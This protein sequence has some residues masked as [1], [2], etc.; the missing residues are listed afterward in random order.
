[1][2]QIHRVFLAGALLL[3][4]AASCFAAEKIFDP[5]ADSAKDLAAAET[6]A[7]Q[8]HKRILLDV[9]GNWCS[10]C[11]LLEHTL[12]ENAALK[13][14]LETNYIVVHV[15][16]SQDRPN[17]AFLSRYPKVDGYPYLFVL[18]PD[19]KLI[20]AQPTDALEQ[21]HKLNSGYN[22]TAVLDFLTKWAPEK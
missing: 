17:E 12:H 22:Q 16:W 21:D 11:H 18:A 15:N 3:A 13:S 7:R 19:G 2:I 9:G 10:W 14:A 6:Q 8:Q 1:M 5:A 20:H 4:T